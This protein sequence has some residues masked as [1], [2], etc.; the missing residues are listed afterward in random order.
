MKLLKRL[1]T[2]LTTSILV[3][4]LICLNFTPK[5]TLAS[6]SQ[7]SSSNISVEEARKKI[8]E[9]AESFAKTEGPKCK[10]DGADGYQSKRA[11]TYAGG[12]PQGVYIFECVGFVNYILHQFLKI[13]FELA[14]SGRGGFVQ[15]LQTRSPGIVD[16][17]HFGYVDINQIQPGDILISSTHVA[18]YVG[19]N[20]TVD[21][22]DANGGH[23]Y[24]DYQSGRA[25]AINSATPGWTTYTRAAR[26][27]SVDGVNF[28]PIEG[29]TDIGDNMNSW[30]TEEVDL[31]EIADQF[32]FDGM[33]PTIVYEDQKVDVFRWLFDG[34]S[35]FMDFIAGLLISFIKAPILGFAGMIDS[36]IDSLLSGMN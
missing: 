36:Y 8:A 28:S 35:G 5:I 32:T 24:L 33:P 12:Y 16:T 27:I 26:L 20:S 11:K 13:D 9:A 31:D 1:C 17:T 21:C 23:D 15:P 3:F 34:I 30:D 22:I 25:V 14:S 2:K 4:C 19:N 18:I 7:Q 6:D 29:G 10:Y